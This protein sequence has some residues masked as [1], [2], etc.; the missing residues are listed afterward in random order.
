MAGLL[1]SILGALGNNTVGQSALPVN[2]PMTEMSQGGGLLSGVDGSGSAMG[3]GAMGAENSLGGLFGTGFLDMNDPKTMIGLQLIDNGSKPPGQMF[4]G[5][6]QIAAYGQRMQQNRQERAAA[7]RDRRDKIEQGSR[8]DEW[9]RQHRPDLAQFIGVVPT[10]ELVKEAWKPKQ[11]KLQVVDGKPFW[12][13]EVAGTF[14][15][16]EGFEPQRKPLSTIGQ[17]QEDYRTGAIDDVGFRVGMQGQLPKG[18]SLHW[19]E[20]GAPSIV[21]NVSETPAFS[22]PSGFQLADPS[23]PDAGVKPIPGGPAEALPSELAARIGMTDTFLKAYPDLRDQIAAGNVTGW[24]DRASIND[25][26]SQQAQTYRKIQSGVDALTRM[27]TGAGMNLAEAS[28]YAER[29]LPS[30]SDDGNSAAQKLD[31]LAQE[32]EAARAAVV[33][34]RGNLPSPSVTSTALNK[35]RKAIAGGA[36]REKVIQ[37]LVENGID[38]EGL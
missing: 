19:D 10:T 22:V 18:M 15:A 36:D 7:E 9:I 33:R 14:E 30:Y 37:R 27:L 12:V 4:D 3:G 2:G 17:L 28:A 26:S 5:V 13:D 16:A 1:S 21:G 23:N 29:Y 8:T 32:L 34:G 6:A 38:P 31:Q 24:I 11:K 35:A 20:N 25:S